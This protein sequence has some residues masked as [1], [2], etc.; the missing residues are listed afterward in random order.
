M[1]VSSFLLTFSRASFRSVEVYRMTCCTGHSAIAAFF[2]PKVA[3]RDLRRYQRRGPDAW[4]RVLISELRRQ[5]L[6]GLHLLDVGGGIGVIA[7]ELADTGL[8][9]VTL[10]DASPAYLDVARRQVT[11]R[12]GARP[13]HFILGDFAVTAATLPDADVVTLDRVVCCYPDVDALLWAASARARRLVAFTYPRDRWY[14]R[15]EIAVENFWYRL[16]G[17]PFRAFVHSPQHM[18]SLLEAAGFVRA[19]PRIPRLVPRPL[20][21]PAFPLNPATAPL[22]HPPLATPSLVEACFALCVKW[23]P[24]TRPLVSMKHLEVLAS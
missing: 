19:A 3:Q 18:A 14:T 5:P 21:P 17:S 10:A 16:R 15:M 9:S 20:P 12:Y 13:T 8:A 7:L 2:D 1:N 24:D 6:R 11:S 23:C 22:S 4:T